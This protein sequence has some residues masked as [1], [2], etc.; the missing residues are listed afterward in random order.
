MYCICMSKLVKTKL[1]NQITDTFSKENVTP[2][3]T[4][5]RY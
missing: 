1:C 3:R 4:H 2:D 5:Y